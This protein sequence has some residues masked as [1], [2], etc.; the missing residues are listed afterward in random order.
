[1][2]N[3]SNACKTTARLRSSNSSPA[4]AVA[5]S[6]AAGK[7]KSSWVATLGWAIH[8]YCSNLPKALSKFKPPQ[9]TRPNKRYM[10][11]PIAPRVQHGCAHR[12][13]ANLTCNADLRPSAAA[14]L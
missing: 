6:V 14:G 9:C 13:S 12:S 5:A 3:C 1:M 4:S 8:H 2:A 10:A 7:Q 11:A